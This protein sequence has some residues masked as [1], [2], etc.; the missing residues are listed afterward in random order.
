MWKAIKGY[1]N[2]RVSDKGE[3]QSNKSGSWKAM[4]LANSLGYRRV[5]LSKDGKVKQ[6]LVHVLVAEM[7][8][9]FKREKN[10]VVH[11]INH[12]RHDNRLENL[13][14]TSQRLNCRRNSEY[15]KQLT[16]RYLGV[17]F[18]KGSQK[19]CAKIDVGGKSVTLGYYSTE[20]EAHNKYQTYVKENNIR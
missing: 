15:S 1:E 5:G 9:G 20:L 14:I 6:F 7:F 18:H 19:W 2:Y 11:H 8:L 12:K 17:H 3:V 10:M 13:E 4:I 16:S